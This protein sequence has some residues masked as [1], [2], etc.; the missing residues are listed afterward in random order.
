MVYCNDSFWLQ[1]LTPRID[2]GVLQ[3]LIHSVILIGYPGSQPVIEAVVPPQMMFSALRRTCISCGRSLLRFAGGPE[4][5]VHLCTRFITLRDA[6]WVASSIGF[7]LYSLLHSRRVWSPV[8]WLGNPTGAM[9]SM[10]EA[11]ISASVH[12]LYESSEFAT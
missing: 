7:S 8:S 2:I 6:S 10:N 11:N 3:G 1:A 5:E 12:L 9:V 4:Q